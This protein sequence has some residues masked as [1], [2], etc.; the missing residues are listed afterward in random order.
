MGLAHF[1]LPTS[2]VEKTAGFFEKTLGYTRNPAPANSP[3]DV[4]WLDIGHG[5]EMHLLHVDAFEASPFEG[6][7]GRHVAVYFPGREFSSLKQRLTAEGAALIEPLRATPFARFFF[8][9]PVNGYV[10]E[11]IDESHLDQ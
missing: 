5:Q 10:F 8:R 9:E 3:I 2:Q 6:E 7:F 4:A 1:T 11:V